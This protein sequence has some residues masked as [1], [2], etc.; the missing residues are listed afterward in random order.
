MHFRRIVGIYI[1]ATLAAPLA[2]QVSE[3]PGDWSESTAEIIQG[4]EST[5][6]QFQPLP[7][8]T[9]TPVI[10]AVSG[11]PDGRYLAV[12]G[13][14]HAIRIIDMQDYQTVQTVIGH[15]D[16]VQSLVFA[17][18]AAS[19]T[20]PTAQATPELYSAGH[21][22]RV[23]RWKFTFPLEAEEVARVPYAIR[24]ICVSSEKKMI[25]IGGFTDEVLLM[26]L[27]EG[28][29]L[30]R[31]QCRTIDQR[32]VRFSPDGRRVLSGSREGEI[33]VW[34]T[35]SGE[36]IASYQEHD[37]RIHAAIFSVDGQQ[38]TSAG[39]DRRIVR[40]HIDERQKVW[41]RELAPSKKMALCLV[42]EHMVAAAGAD[43]RIRL[44]DTQTNSV[45]AEMEGHQGTVAAMAA[46][47]EFLASGS[48]DTTVR[49]WNL[50]ELEKTRTRLSIPTSMT[51]I[52]IDQRLQI[53]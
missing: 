47:G 49:L 19:A 42:N 26:D 34:D 25:A 36:L 33:S 40:Y 2:A 5:E 13:D 43:N 52:K 6:I 20:E 4:A 24:S 1:C 9:S 31:L 8:L 15:D 17:Y 35:G 23:L 44:F 30:H 32:C 46:C 51:P 29:Y 7:G 41:H 10:T 16:W 39:E 14:D 45:I 28:R 53:R 22:G 38:V 11:S 37:S 12:A 3:G 50:N 18:P 48:F 27:F 21:D